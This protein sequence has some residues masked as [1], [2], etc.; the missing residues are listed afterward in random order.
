VDPGAELTLQIVCFLQSEPDAPASPARWALVPGAGGGADTF[1]EAAARLAALDKPVVVG[2]LNF[3]GFVAVWRTTALEASER[4]HVQH[5]LR[6]QLRALEAK[7]APFGLGDEDLVLFEGWGVRVS[8]PLHV[9]RRWL[10]EYA[11]TWG[12]SVRP[13]TDPS[14]AARL[15]VLHADRRWSPGFVCTRR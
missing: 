7:V 6:N 2:A 10:G 5:T 3:P 14:H 15:L 13:P 9:V 4:A 8:V 12:W 11:L 1:A